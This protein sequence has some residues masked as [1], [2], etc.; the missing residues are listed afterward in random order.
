MWLVFVF[1]LL[2]L[3]LL[4][5][6]VLLE[7]FVVRARVAWD[8]IFG[9]PPPAGARKVMRPPPTMVAPSQLLSEQVGKKKDA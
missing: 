4:C 1:L 7:Y 6:S 2:L 8:K 3:L 9:T 5:P